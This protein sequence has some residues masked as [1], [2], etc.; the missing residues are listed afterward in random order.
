MS[1][2]PPRLRS[3]PRFVDRSIR[4]RVLSI[5]GVVAA[6]VLA[7]GGYAAH[8]IGSGAD[9]GDVLMRANTATGAA[10][11]ADMMH[12]AIRSDVLQVLG[13]PD[14]PGARLS[15]AADL[16]QHAAALQD[17]LD[18]VRAAHL[19]A[20]VD[21]AL[22]DATPIVEV[23]LTA[24]SSWM[25]TAEEDPARARAAYPSFLQAF[26]T[27]EDT[28][29]VVTDA[30]AQHAVAAQQ[31]VEA[32]RGAVTRLLV[33]ASIGLV[34]VLA[35]GLLLT[36]SLV[37]PLDRV[38]AVLEALAEGDLT[39][40]ADVDSRDELGQMAAALE[41][42]TERLRATVRDI[43]LAAQELADSSADLSRV[44]AQMSDSASGSA[45]SALQ[46]STAAGQVSEHVHAVA[47]GTEEMSASIREIAQST[48]SAAVVATEAVTIAQSTTELV[49]QLGESSTQIGNVVKLISSIAGQTNLL[50]LNAT[51]EAARAGDAGKGFAV[52]A[53]E[54]KELAD[55]TGSATEDIERQ[56]AAIQRDTVRAAD[57]IGR[58]SAV[59]DQVNDTQAA[60]ASAIEQQTAT[61]AEMSHGVAEAATGSGTI[62]QTIDEVARL[63]GDTTDASSATRAAADG[64]SAVSMRMRGLVGQF[65]Y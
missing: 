61:S 35:L 42:A 11:Q 9:R 49:T 54:V 59:I 62:A 7:L 1:L 5:V 2:A 48:S 29:P 26:H 39:R 53:G 28:L 32:Q 16:E 57:A 60:I 23:Y 65:R 15:A 64:L 27:L 56:V 44:S 4:T 46:V 37:R 21:R 58:I 14:D 38:R 25:T 8:L 22:A 36:R 10:L 47:A 3:L 24:A 13:N 43:D 34:V 33:G 50:A 31:G 12:D 30:V 63:A 19:G 20:D 52:V 55:Q 18:E 51:I 40:H 6:V 17:S 41:R 45:A